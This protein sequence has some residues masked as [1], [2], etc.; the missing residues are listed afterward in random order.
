MQLSFEEVFTYAHLYK[1]YKKCRRGVGWKP[2]TQTYKSN[3]FVN[4]RKTQKQLLNGTWKSKGFIEFGITDRGKKRHIKSVHISERV[5]QR[6]LCDYCLTPALSKSLIPDNSASQTGKGM[7]YAIRRLC[8]QL[9]RHYQKY[10]TEGYIGMT[11]FHKFFESISHQACFGLADR[12][13]EDKRLQD[14]TKYLVS[15]FGEKGLGLGSQVSQNLAISVPSRLDHMVKERFGKLYG[16]YMDDA[17][18]IHPDKEHV[19]KCL[20]AIREEAKRFGVSMNDRKTQIIKLS[21]GFAFLKIRFI[22]TDSGFVV[23]KLG[24]ESITRER[25]KI[26]KLAKKLPPEDV[27]T[28]FTSWKGH[29]KRCHSRRTVQAMERVYKQCMQKSTEK[30]TR[31]TV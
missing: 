31:S 3:A 29:A 5:V 23:R 1:S 7:D 9:R 25:R 8:K 6:C 24:R 19:M 16:R 27:K 13:I 26:K 21:R 14:L 2:S 11:D 4:V 20:N 15:M 17:Y 10:G 22:L 28:S 12:Y 30:G 18:F